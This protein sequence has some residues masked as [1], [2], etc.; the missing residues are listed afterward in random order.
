M[1]TPEAPSQPAGTWRIGRFAGVDLLARPSLLLM[2]VV[3]VVLFA[4]RYED[5]TQ[6][7]PYLVAAV[8]V[9]ALYASILL[10][11][12]AHVLAARGFGMHVPSVTLHLLGG[13]TAIEGESRTPWQELATAIVGPIVSLAI[14][15]AGSQAA[16]TMGPGVL[17]DVV[18]SIGW[19]NILVAVFNM[20]PG[21]P[22]DGGRVFKAIVWQLTGHEETGT[23]VAAWIGRAAAVALI[24]VTLI[25][26][27]FTDNGW[28]FD[29]IISA[30]VAWFLWEGAGHALAHAKRTTR[31][32]RLSVRTLVE[33]GVAP[34]GAPR[35]PVDIGGSVLVRAMA[36][37]PAETYAVIERDGSVVGVLHSARVDEAWQSGR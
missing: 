11:E 18:W 19:V 26:A 6:M 12:I 14:G 8:F 17:H 28:T 13:E 4:P 9:V 20:L 27:D 2:G 5:Q 22:L 31:L 30:V 35:L 15:I 32:N 37:R 10:H 24:A 34:E 36:A 25:R 1:S 33:P 3:L 7:N 16:S 23:R 29:V 21:L